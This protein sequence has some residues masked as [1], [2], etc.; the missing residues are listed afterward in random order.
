MA[1]AP[2]L[3]LHPA[4]CLALAAAFL[5]FGWW[6]FAGL[7][8]RMALAFI[9]L[10]VAAAGAARVSL[11][12]RAYD[13]NPLRTY[14]SDGYLD[15]EG[16][17]LR[18]PE[19]EP[20]RDVLFLRV[21]SIRDAGRERTLRGN[22]RLSIPFAPDLRPRLDLRAGDRISASVR[23]VPGTS[24]R[25]FGG[26]SYERYLKGLKVHRR[27]T[28]KTSLLV[29]KIPGNRPPGV[30]VRTLVSRVRCA[31]QTGLERRF[32][33]VDG[34][35]IG[36][37]G[38]VLEALLLGENGR[39]DPGTVR[40]LQE[41]GLYHLFAISGAHI[42][43]LTFLLFSLFR[44][45]RMPDRAARLALMAFLLFYAMLI[46]GRP[47]V[48]RATFMTLFFLAGKLLWK[49]VHALNT[50]AASAFFLLLANPGALYDLGFQ[51]TYAATLSIVLFYRPI[52]GRLPRLPLRVSEMTALS[53]S[54]LL[55]A[56]PLIA[57]N[58]NRV[59]FASLLLNG[60]A[61][62]LV[63]LI[64]GAG[65]ASLPLAAVLPLTAKLQAEGLG[66][67][68]HVFL[69]LSHL[70]SPLSFLSYRVPTPPAWAL[71][72]YFLFLGLT[73]VR[74]RIRGQRRLALA[75]FGLFFIILVSHPFSSSSPDLKVTMIDVGQGD[76]FLVEFPGRR[77][78][79]IDGGGFAGS[80]FDVGERVVSPFL[81]SKGI[82]R[83]DIMVITHPHPDHFGGLAA[84]A[85]NFRIGEFWEA[86]PA[87]EDKGYAEF[88]RGLPRTAAHKRVLRGFRHREGK[89]VIEALHPEHAGAGGAGAAANESSL[90][91]RIALGEVSFLLTGDIGA[92]TERELLDAGGELRST[93]LKAPH[94]GSAYSS[95]P[96]FLEAVGPGIALVSAG[97]GN[98]YGFPSPTVLDRY[99][100]A[101][102]R[103]FRT[104]VHG[105]VEVRTD[106]RRLGVRI[107][108]RGPAPDGD[109][110]LTRATK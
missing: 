91:L 53:L 73:L 50:I 1:A 87:P 97:Q 52:F 62:P 6:S 79:L 101:G 19:R 77:T 21:R 60:A 41:S 78:M 106:G 34:L 89:V 110:P 103:V 105:A 92:A 56:L 82:R 94:H 107:A 23:L 64:M 33:S 96:A 10:A 35:D 36:P 67:L 86:S 38:A 30:P 65:Y 76:S 12:D 25:N 44:L 57:M 14:E 81:W 48:L 66:S 85:R 11:H 71:A 43:I 15:V 26:F 4:L 102:A 17:L 29:R 69:W 84:V 37:E 104:D 98:T 45:V 42:A 3:N 40:D 74:P 28:T 54:A 63:G 68:V 55:G 16:T 18:S 75:V 39:L 108:R 32:P 13:A 70:P 9:L 83:V 49:D 20:D 99:M 93:V 72:G 61:V 24:F 88:A 51:L 7:K 2:A 80:P 47:S 90:V 27:A 46:E 31:I 5:A 59:T 58:F 100:E 22:L 109:F 8:G 95:S